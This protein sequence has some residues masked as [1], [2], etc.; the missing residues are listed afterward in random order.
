MR[1][2]RS[3]RHA[4]ILA[5][6][7]SLTSTGY[8][9]R[10]GEGAVTGRFLPKKLL[11]SARMVFIREELRRLIE[12]VQPDL[13]AYEGYAMNAVGRVFNIGELGGVVRTLIWEMGIDLIVWA[14]PQIK[15]AITGSGRAGKN[16]KDSARKQAKSKGKAPVPNMCDC[17][18]ER[19]GYYIDQDDE[20]DAFALL[21]L[22]ELRAGICRQPGAFNVQ[23]KSIVSAGE[24]I[25]G[26]KKQPGMQLIANKRR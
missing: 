6:D 23:A 8:A 18:S 21:N 15:L 12:E 24:L 22:A 7:V 26:R 10:D 14:P 11:G 4:K 13:I 3:T 19:F 17:I 20:A 5:L 25:P 2:T 1:I 16:K 9:Y